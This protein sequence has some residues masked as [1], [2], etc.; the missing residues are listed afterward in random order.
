MTVKMLL[1]IINVVLIVLAIF[2]LIILWCV[3]PPDSPWTPWWRTNS[4]KAIAAGKLAKISS[5][6]LIYELGSGDANFLVTVCRKYKCRGVGIEIDFIRILQA[7][8][9]AMK[10]GVSE[11]I[12][13]K[14]GS[15][16]DYRLGDATV[17]FCYLVPRV[18]EKLKPKLK[19][20]LKK[21]T[22]IISY[23]YKFQP[24]K[25]IKFIAT[26]KKSEMNLYKIA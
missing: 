25:K 14:R 21:G 2:L 15:F 13:L 11:N 8:I 20:E 17:I 18:L 12:K 4:K 19:K 16:Y 6:D 7:K 9:N 3:W 10:N 23:R 1:F 24:D 26:D 5:N 22:K